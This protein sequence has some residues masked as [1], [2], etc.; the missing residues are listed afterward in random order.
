MAND[1][2]S[3]SIEE[4]GYTNINRINKLYENNYKKELLQNFL[5]STTTSYPIVNI[6]NGIQSIVTR[7]SVLKLLKLDN[8]NITDYASNNFLSL[9]KS[10]N[11][12]DA[13]KL[14]FKASNSIDIDV[15]DIIYIVEEQYGI[16]NII[17]RLSIK[18]IFKHE[19]I[20]EYLSKTNIQALINTESMTLASSENT[21]NAFVV[22][23]NNSKSDL[24]IIDQ[25]K[26]LPIG[27]LTGDRLFKYLLF[28]NKSISVDKLM[29]KIR[30][31]NKVTP[32]TKLSDLLTLLNDF[33]I[34]T[35]PVFSN[36]KFIGSIN[37]KDILNYLLNNTG[38]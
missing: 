4:L 36:K 15:K 37:Y 34:G 3:I 35:Y 33:N 10:N 21:D 2:L 16:K 12:I 28:N 25:E 30:H 9:K 8:K 17:G 7:E 18:D 23:M 11:L 29:F 1:L 38:F 26:K 5:M 19:E 20:I 14:L 13:I 6:N 31:I 22:Y 24:I 32:K 27:I